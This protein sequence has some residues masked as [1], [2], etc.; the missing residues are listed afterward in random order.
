MEEGVAL[1]A[2]VN[3]RALHAGQHFGD[4]AL[5]DVA[6]HTARTF[7]LD[8]DLDDLIVLQDRDPRV[9]LRRGDDHLLAH[10]HSSVGF[11]RRPATAR[12][13][14]RRANVPMRISFDAA[15]KYV[16][17][18]LGNGETALGSVQ[19]ADF[20]IE[21]GSYGDPHVRPGPVAQWDLPERGSAAGHEVD[22]R[23]E[24]TQERRHLLGGVLEVAVHETE[25]LAARIINAGAERRRLAEIAP[26]ADDVHAG[27]VLVDVG[28]HLEGLVGRAVIH[29]HR[30]PVRS[31]L[32]DE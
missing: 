28:E 6:D 2:D 29:D 10:A 11:D 22:A 15:K 18:Y 31:A 13:T 17:L 9:V 4:P 24:R 20:S 5:V 30:T 25:N 19:P 26:K 27:V 21:R 7:A 3:E 14:A 32:G 12:R 8:E 23:A 16:G 1:E